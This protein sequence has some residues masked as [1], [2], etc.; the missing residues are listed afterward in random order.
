MKKMDSMQNHLQQNPIVSN[1]AS[2]KSRND[3]GGTQSM[4]TSY[5]R[6]QGR[7]MEETSKSKSKGA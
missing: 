2:Q 1:A 6:R 7:L 3:G 4:N 5:R